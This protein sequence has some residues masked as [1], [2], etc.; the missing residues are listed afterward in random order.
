LSKGFQAE[1]IDQVLH[2]LAEVG[3]INDADFAHQWVRSRHEH[4][5]KGRRALAQELRQKGIGPAEAEAALAGVSADEERGRAVELVRRKLR[6]VNTDDLADKAQW[7]K[8]IRRLAGMLA[9][10]G[11][12]Q[13]MAFDVVKTELQAAGAAAAAPPH[14]HDG[15]DE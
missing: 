13:A 9:R 12:G 6:S 4:S 7:E 10:R 1:I 2:R 3:L 11:Y 5:G 8:M 15:R 14:W